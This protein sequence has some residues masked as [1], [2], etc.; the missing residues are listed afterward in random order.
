MS[1]TTRHHVNIPGTKNTATVQRQHQRNSRMKNS[2]SAESS[3]KFVK[4]TRI[5]ARTHARIHWITDISLSRFFRFYFRS[6]F[7]HFFSV[8]SVCSWTDDSVIILRNDF[9]SCWTEN[10]P[11]ILEAACQNVVKR[12]EKKQQRKREWER[13][14]A[15]PAKL[16]RSADAHMWMD[17]D[18]R[19][20]HYCQRNYY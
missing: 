7:L 11:R 9:F 4:L 2:N 1:F 15:E 19:F 20:H 16:K 13:A 8:C 17:F 12:T 18:V 5:N 14:L 10:K 3:S 6:F